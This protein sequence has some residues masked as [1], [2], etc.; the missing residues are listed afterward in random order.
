[1]NLSN[2]VLY[3]LDQDQQSGKVISADDYIPPFIQER[4]A[5]DSLQILKSATDAIQNRAITRDNSE[6]ER[7]MER[8]VQIFNSL[9]NSD[10]LNEAQGWLFMACVKLAR[11]QQGEFHMDD[12]ID[13]AAYVALAGESAAKAVNDGPER[14]DGS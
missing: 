11:S 9:I 14:P 4:K 5:Q 1:M 6:T 8:T 3:V 7:S 13:A 12:Y 10:L 2:D